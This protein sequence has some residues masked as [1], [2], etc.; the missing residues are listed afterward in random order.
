MDKDSSLTAKESFRLITQI[1]EKKKIELNENGFIY[2]FWGWLIILASGAHLALA[3][4]GYFDYLGWMWGIVTGLGWAYSLFYFA[5]IRKKSASTQ[6]P[7]LGNILLGLWIYIG[8]SYLILFV[9]LNE[10]ITEYIYLI[11]LLLYGLGT[12]VSGL[13]LQFRPL[14][15]AGIA[16]QLLAFSTFLIPFQYQISLLIVSQIIGNLIPGYLLRFKYKK[17]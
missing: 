2:L 11:M 9:F 13:V 5:Q 8:V 3:L 6:S 10:Y 15:Y 1:I 4:N 14:I 17:S 16:C 12:L 7:L